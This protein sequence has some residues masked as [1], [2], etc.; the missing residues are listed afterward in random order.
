MFKAKSIQH[1]LK[2][3]A[4]VLSATIANAR[5]GEDEKELT[6]RFGQPSLRSNHSIVSQ[7]KI[8]SLGPTLIFKQDDWLIQADLVDGRCVRIHYSKPG[9]WTEKQFSFVLDAN[10]QGARWSE[11]SKKE[12]SKFKREWKRSDSATAEWSR[13]GAMIVVSPAYQRAV[14]NA[15]QKAKAEAS[16]DPKI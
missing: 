10:A 16:R 12:L 2:I 9:D 3:V 6:T 4:F 5:L 14:A 8:R 7:G 1:F 11:I 13:G 15:E